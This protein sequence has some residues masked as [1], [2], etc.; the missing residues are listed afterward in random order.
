[1]TQFNIT[2]DEQDLSNNT[3][4]VKTQT[5]DMTPIYIGVP[6]AVILLATLIGLYF[7]CRSDKSKQEGDIDETGVEM[8][9]VGRASTMHPAAETP[10]P[11]QHKMCW[12]FYQSDYS[13]LRDVTGNDG[14]GD[15]K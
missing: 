5:T 1:M 13:T 9:T 14:L 6:V 3:V 7:I 15:I 4:E 8:L 11:F 12:I 2:V 10:Y